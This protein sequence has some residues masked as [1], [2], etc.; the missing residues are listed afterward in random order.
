LK[1]IQKSGL[2]KGKRR[3]HLQREIRFMKLLSHPHICISFFFQFFSFFDSF[4][5]VLGLLYDVIEQD[6]S[7]V[8]IMEHAGGGEL[9]DC[10][11][12]ADKHRLKEKDARRLYRFIIIILLILK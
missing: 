10:I 3:I 12:N 8:L 7:Y 9:L 1:F 2:N 4:F 5:I 11:K 6:E